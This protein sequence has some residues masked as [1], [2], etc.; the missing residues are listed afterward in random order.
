M[1]PSGDKILKQDKNRVIRIHANDN[2]AVALENLNKGTT[3]IIDGKSCILN[4]NINVKHKFTLYDINAG[5]SIVLYGIKVGQ[6]VTDI[7]E[8]SSI[9]TT[10]TIN[11]TVEIQRN[12]PRSYK[13]EPPPVSAYRNRT[14]MGY[15]RTDGQ[16]GTANYWIVIPMVF[17]ENQLLE[18]IKEDILTEFG[19]KKGSKYKK[20]IRNLI[21]KY[22]EESDGNNTMDDNPGGSLHPAGRRLFYNVSGIQFLTHDGGCGCTRRDARELC[23]LLAGYITHP[24]VAGATVLSLGCQNAELSLLHE[25]IKKRDPDFSKPYFEFDHQKTGVQDEIIKQVID[26][27]FRGLIIANKAERKPAPLSKL[28]VGLECGGSDGFSGISANPAIG[29][30]SDLI[31]ALGGTTILSEFPELSGIEQDLYDRCKLQADGDKFLDLMI[32][33]NNMAEYVGSGF[34]ANPSPGNIRDGLITDAM[35]SAGAA[36]KGGSAPISGVL[37]YTEKAV[38]TGLNLLCTPG[39]DVESVTA[40]VASG[41]N[42]VLFTTGMGTPTGNP[43]VPVIK[44]SSNTPT[45]LKMPDI[46]DINSGKIIDGEESIEQCG[47]RILNYMIDVAGGLKEPSAVQNGQTDFIP[48]RRGVSL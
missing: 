2:V 12:T 27:I 38:N 33:Y 30:V 23:S 3:V 14:F 9:T 37:D 16:V 24:N 19:Y 17:C 31:V 29:Y 35:K 32:S 8:G 43:I 25:E 15:Y 11:G 39:N 20:Y 18:S 22:K 45:F 47:K 34:Y 5:D 28:C 36:K 46:I 7:P 26:S 41:A 1:E 42:I 10:N 4:E 13:W 44:I 48:W 6:A 21:T 40:E